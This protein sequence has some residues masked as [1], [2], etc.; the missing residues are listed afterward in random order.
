ARSAPGATRTIEGKGAASG[1]KVKLVDVRVTEL[2]T[3]LHLVTTER[4]VEV[5]CHV[6]RDVGTSGGLRGAGLV[7][8]GDEDR[9]RAGCNDRVGDAQVEAGVRLRMEVLIRVVEGLEEIVRREGHD[10][11]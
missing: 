10:I 8:A 5:I 4:P 7:E 11:K 3:E 1:G 2:A 6:P 9:R